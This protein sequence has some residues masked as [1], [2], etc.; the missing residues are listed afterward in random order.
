MFLRI[1]LQFEHA[2]A[3]DVPDG[4]DCCPDC[5]LSVCGNKQI[6]WQDNVFVPGGGR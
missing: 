6:F 5:S 4:L 1:D 2:L 3:G